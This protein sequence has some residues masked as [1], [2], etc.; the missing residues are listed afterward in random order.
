M[1]SIID[2]RAISTVR[3]LREDL[4]ISK[5]TK[6]SLDTII[7]KLNIAVRKADLGEGILGACKTVGLRRL[8]VINPNIKYIEQERFT[9]AHEIGHILIHHGSHYCTKESFNMW[10]S[11]SE[12]EYEANA[13]AAELLLPR[14]V[15]VE[16][17]S[18]EDISI[19]MI[20]SIAKSYETS[21]SAT[22]I[23]LVKLYNDAAAV[24]FHKSGKVIWKV[25]SPECYFSITGEEITSPITYKV[26]KDNVFAKGYVNACKWVDSNIDNLECYEETLY[27]PKLKSYLTI[28]KFMKSDV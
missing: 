25:K 5:S 27:F 12:K 16:L 1:N 18:K 22:A 14:K 2:D 24:V 11:A 13:F 7:T 26:D 21:M 17:L 15:M 8:I 20:S 23:R 10:K 6:V 4:Q 28:L 9:L 19:P 3:N